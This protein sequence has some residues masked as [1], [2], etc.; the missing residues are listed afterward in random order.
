VEKAILVLVP[1]LLATVALAARRPQE[2]VDVHTS[3]SARE[4]ITTA[5]E[6]WGRARVELDREAMD[7]ALAPEFRVLLADRELSREEFLGQISQARLGA[8]LTRFDVSVL[9]VREADPGWIAVI[10]EKL[11]LEVP[12][13]G[14]PGETRTVYSFWVTRDGFRVEDGVWLATSSEEIG[15]EN[16][17]DTAPPFPDW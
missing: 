17:T 8:R 1:A 14:G 12:V 4:A 7:A 2:Q 16:W 11:E 13:P 5:Y 6:E 9:T 10:T 3:E 15:H